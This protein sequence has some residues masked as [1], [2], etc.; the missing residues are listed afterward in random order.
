MD[1]AIEQCG[2]RV[3]T[4]FGQVNT[5]GGRVGLSVKI[6]NCTATLFALVVRCSDLRVI[7]GNDFLAFAKARLHYDEGRIGLYNFQTAQ[8]DWVQ[9]FVPPS[10]PTAPEVVCL[11]TDGCTDAARMARTPSISGGE[12]GHQVSLHDRRDP[13]SSLQQPGPAQGPSSSH[14]TQTTLTN[15]LMPRRTLP[16]PPSVTQQPSSAGPSNAASLDPIELLDQGSD[17]AADDVTAQ[18]HTC[19]VVKPHDKMLLC[20]ACGDNHH[21]SCSKMDPIEQLTDDGWY[22]P[23]CR[24]EAMV[25]C[26]QAN[27]P[28]MDVHEDEAVMA[29]LLT[30]IIPQDEDLTPDQR[31]ALHRRVVKR[32]NNYEADD[33]GEIYMIT[34]GPAGVRRRVPRPADRMAIIEQT[35]NDLSHLGVTKTLQTLQLRFYWPCMKQD[36][37]SFVNSCERCQQRKLIL[38][39]QNTLTPLPIVGIWHRVHIDCMGPYPITHAGNRTVFPNGLRPKPFQTTSVAPLPRSSTK[40]FWHATAACVSS[41][42]TEDQSSAAQRWPTSSSVTTSSSTSLRATSQTAMDR[43]NALWA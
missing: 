11:M 27:R 38:V 4:T 13:S 7:L 39:K 37:S 30:G 19:G 42:A 34:P 12:C 23:A 3:G 20:A 43:P 16:K 41:A 1:L 5:I 17:D 25:S 36:V 29:F 9:L 22:C 15:L 32:A 8:H 10:H 31:R 35:H 26:K 33:L 14:T 2:L 28:C 21:L 40:S 6:A 24:P 18:C